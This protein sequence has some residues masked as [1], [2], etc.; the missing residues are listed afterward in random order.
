MVEKHVE[1]D[2]DNW[3]DAAKIANTMKRPI[4]QAEPSLEVVAMCLCNTVSYECECDCYDSV[5][6]LVG[7]CN[8]CGF[9]ILERGCSA[10]CN[11]QHQHSPSDPKYTGGGGWVSTEHGHVQ[12][13]SQ[14]CRDADKAN[15]PEVEVLDR[16]ADI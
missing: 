12:W 15:D 6:E 1:L 14:A 5:H 7:P 13:C 10:A 2:A 11:D 9:Q 4:V 3:Q 16:M 8:K